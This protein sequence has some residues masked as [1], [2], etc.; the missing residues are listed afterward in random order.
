MT[1]TLGPLREILISVQQPQTWLKL[2]C[3]YGGWDLICSDSA[4]QNWLKSWDLPPDQQASEYLIQFQG[5]EHGSIR[6]LQYQ[7]GTREQL[8]PSGKIWDTGGISDID[9]RVHNILH[10][11]HDLVDEGWHGANVPMDMPA[12]PFKLDEVLLS[13]PDGVMLALVQRHFP[14]L[15]LPL[16]KNLASHIYL[17]AMTVKNL[18]AAEHFFIHQLGFVKLNQIPIRFP[19]NQMN[20][21]GLPHNF[22]DA[23]TCNLSMFSPDGSRE[24]M[25]QVMSFDGLVG[26][27]FSS[28]MKAP[29]R[30]IQAY[31]IEVNNLPDYRDQVIAN[32]L[33]CPAIVQDE[34]QP[35]GPV[36]FFKI[37]SP[38]M[39]W[40]EFFEVI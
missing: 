3:E 8:R 5:L 4:K 33:A 21:F 7:P 38:E 16:D 31:R 20:N 10:V 19:A 29:Y 23:F 6:F 15:E 37:A 1:P 11:F 25:L 35:Y 39:A 9:I 17:S 18:A 13:G 22:S 14:S 24:T 36:H 32:G 26:T 12:P 34:W 40:I 28:R 2:F 27:D 30:G